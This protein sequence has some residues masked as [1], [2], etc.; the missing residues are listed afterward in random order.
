MNP[1]SLNIIYD[2]EKK[3]EKFFKVNGID[4]FFHKIKNNIEEKQDILIFNWIQQRKI[5]YKQYKKL[6]VGIKFIRQL[7]N[8]LIT[9]GEINV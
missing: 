1:E 7:K 3:I 9:I 4:K 6:K 2:T 5:T 8:N